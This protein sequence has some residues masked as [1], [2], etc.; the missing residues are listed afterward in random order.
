MKGTFAL[1]IVLGLMLAVFADAR[2]VEGVTSCTGTQVFPSQ[3][4]SSVAGSKP[5]GTTFC[6]RDGAHNVSNSVVV[7]DGDKF[8]GVFSDGSRPTVTTTTVRDIFNAYPSNGAT[9]R[10]LSISGAV[11]NNQ[12]EPDCG[13]WWEEPYCKRRTCSPQCQPGHRRHGYRALGDQLRD[14]PQWQLLLHQ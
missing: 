10:D 11:G 4:L 6:V 12:C 3:S 13:R 14:R 8:I 5:P 7:Q 1:C 2:Q 9:I